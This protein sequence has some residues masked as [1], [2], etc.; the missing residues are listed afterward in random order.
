MLGVLALVLATSA[1]EAVVAR[2]FA[3]TADGAF[4]SYSWGEHWSRLRG[5]L[6]GFAGDLRTFL[7][8]GPWVFAGGS[9]GLYVSED[10][11]ETYRPD[12]RW[13]GDS[14]EVTSLLSSR[15]FGLD[16]TL[17]VGTTRGLYRSIGPGEKWVRVGADAIRSEVREMHWPGPELFVA[18]ADGLYRTVD[19]G[20]SWVKLGNGLPGGA[21]IS[22]LTVS[23]FFAVE[24][25]L[26]VG[27]EGAGLHK[28]T[29]GGERFAPIADDLL[30][31]ETIRSLFWWGSLLLVGTE[32]GLYASDDSGATLR[33]AKDIGELP[34]LSI[35]VPGAEHDVP[36]DLIVGTARGVFKSSDGGQSFRRVVEGMGQIEVRALATF[37][38]PPQ[39][40][41]RRSR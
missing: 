2:L 40:R 15:L 14:P 3:A 18:A 13:P 4:I 30:K 35:S 20:E 16:P 24:P 27:T 9:G 12:E 25:T 6:R 38:L 33:R 10:F 28:S 22:A 21:A 5:D 23:R 34:V 17:F 31:T 37:P 19:Q 11:G 26:F 36:S 8:L 39:H 1:Q 29:D 32:S 41:E 7:C